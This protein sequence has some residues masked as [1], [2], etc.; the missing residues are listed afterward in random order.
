MSGA[1]SSAADATRHA[2]RVNIVLRRGSAA[3]SDPR[4]K[5]KGKVNKT[6]TG[7]PLKGG[8]ERKRSFAPRPGRKSDSLHQLANTLDWGQRRDLTLAFILHSPR[9][10]CVCV[11]VCTTHITQKSRL[12]STLQ[13]EL[14]GRGEAAFLRLGAPLT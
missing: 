10:A 8:G 12:S 5:Q 11:C 9:C 1:G 7:P 13:L 3:L 2:P 4:G 6:P 14:K